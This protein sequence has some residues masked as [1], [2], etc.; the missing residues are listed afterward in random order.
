MRKVILGLLMI[1]LSISITS[2]GGDISKS[3]TNEKNVTTKDSND[4]KTSSNVWDEIKVVD[5][6]GDDTGKRVYSKIFEGNF[7]NSATE[8]SKLKIQVIKRDSSYNFKLYEYGRNLVRLSGNDNALGDITIKDNTNE[9]NHYEVF[10]MR[11]GIIY[12][13]NTS[14]LY[15]I[16]SIPNN[17]LK[18]VIR[19]GNFSRLN[20]S[21][22]YNFKITTK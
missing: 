15:K 18:I 12:I 3:I 4:H 8:N 7:S 21:S 9:V 10:S 22:I 1:V 14:D 16:M 20:R 5:Q 11:D 13:S 6:F 2:C 17:E 19:G